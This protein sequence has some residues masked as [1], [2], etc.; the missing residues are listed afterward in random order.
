MRNGMPKVLL[1]ATQLEPGGA[2]NLVLWQSTKLSK[3]FDT[4]VAFLYHKADFSRFQ[5]GDCFSLARPNGLRSL[6]VVLARLSRAMQAND[7]VIAHTH[8]SIILAALAKLLFA[9]RVHLIAVHH[10]E[11]TLYSKIVGKLLG[12]R[13]VRAQIDRNVFVASHIIIGSNYEVIHNPSEVSKKGKIALN[14][15]YADLLFVGRLS[16]E[17]N[18][19]TLLQA[20]H[21]LPERS[22]TIIGDGQERISLEIAAQELGVEKRVDFIGSVSKEEVFAYMEGCSALIIPSTTEA[23]PMVLIEGL[24]R[25]SSIICS[26]IPAHSFAIKSGCVHS[27]PAR[28][29]KSLAAAVRNLD[30]LPKPSQNR[31]KLLLKDF[32][33]AKV[34]GQWS[35][36]IDKCLAIDSKK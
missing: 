14:A 25:T 18:I 12:S 30:N 10:S 24:S 19:P 4:S 13:L 28:D 23:L 7:I 2:Q 31:R 1:L 34:L 8:Y 17:K 22:L 15:A 32:D 5:S 35:A 29:P 16:P 20:L 11:S 6:S 33:E 9:R 21:L 27:F 26:A 36:L 3:R